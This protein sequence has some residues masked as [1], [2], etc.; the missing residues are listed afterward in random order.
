MMLSIDLGLG[1]YWSRKMSFHI[2]KSKRERFERGLHVGDTPFGYRTGASTKDPLVPVPEEAA[3][4][5]EAVRD[6]AAGAG[7]AEIARRWNAQGRRPRSKQ[8]HTT[9]TTS[10]LQSIIE[11]D[12][13]AGFVRHKGER[14]RGAHQA[15]IS[16]DLWLAAQERVRRQPSHARQPRMLAGIARCSECDG[17]IHQ[18]KCGRG[19]GHAYYRE[20]SHLRGQPCASGGKM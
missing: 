19:N 17:P 3:A 6:Y 9:F 2:R 20:T 12:F 10:A 4:I 7:Y 16:E 18:T 13:Y 14:R 15:I 11:N 1:S 8:G 5:A